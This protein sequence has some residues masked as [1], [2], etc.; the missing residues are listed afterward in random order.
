MG[1]LDHGFKRFIQIVSR[2]CFLAD[3][4]S[5]SSY[6]IMHKDSTEGKSRR[7]DET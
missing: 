2:H 6:T 5:R 3:H 4:L 7:N 1:K